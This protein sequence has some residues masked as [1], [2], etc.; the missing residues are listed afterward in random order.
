[1]LT[2]WQV[3][4]HDKLLSLIQSPTH[5]VHLFNVSLSTTPFALAFSLFAYKLEQ[6]SSSDMF[7]P[8]IDF[9]RYMK[10]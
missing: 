8:E 10:D 4:N 1:L 2:L 9:Y 6:C 7:V 3:Q 5:L